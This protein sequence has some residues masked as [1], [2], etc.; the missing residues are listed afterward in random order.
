MACI[1]VVGNKEGRDGKAAALEKKW[2]ALH[3]EAQVLVLPQGENVFDAR[4]QGEE[5][6]PLVF[7]LLP[8]DFVQENSFDFTDTGS[9]LEQMLIDD[10]LAAGDDMQNF[11]KQLEKSIKK[12]IAARG[13][14]LKKTIEDLKKDAYDDALKNGRDPA[15]AI[16]NLDELL[17][18]PPEKGGT[19]MKTSNRS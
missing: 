11:G 6:R 13:K 8:K 12:R 17:I 16:K 14:V 1:V 15:K 7:K 18:P 5:L 19:F 9:G 3:K 4:K 2:R 10:A